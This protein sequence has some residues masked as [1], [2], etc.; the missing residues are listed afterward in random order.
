[1][2]F[3]R[4]RF[5]RIVC[6]L[7]FFISSLKCC[8]RLLAKPPSNML[9][10]MIT[11]LHLYLLVTFLPPNSPQNSAHDLSNLLCRLPILHFTSKVY[12]SYP[13]TINIFA[14][15]PHSLPLKRA[16]LKYVFFQ[17]T[18][19]IADLKTPLGS[20]LFCTGLNEHN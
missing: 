10:L 11:A 13:L 15:Y 16:K 14:S 4:I 5:C 20:W 17:V 7:N 1:M 2:S 18:K 9:P 19:A 8:S 6:D 3:T 12:F